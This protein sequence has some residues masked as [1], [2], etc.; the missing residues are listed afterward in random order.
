M[1]DSEE[2]IVRFVAED[3]PGLGKGAI[4]IKR[5]KDTINLFRSDPPTNWTIQ[6]ITNMVFGMRIYLPLYE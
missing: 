3:A 2:E 6:M 1:I 4:I 5:E